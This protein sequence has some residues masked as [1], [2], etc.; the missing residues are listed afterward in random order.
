MGVG[1]SG[2]A[3]TIA[4]EVV[5]VGTLD[6]RVRFYPS[7]TSGFFMNAGLGLGT[8]SVDD[9]TEYG[10]GAMLGLGWDIRVGRNVSLTPFWNGFAMSNANGDAN[11]GQLGLGFTIH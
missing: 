11:V 4:G 5:S 3:R 8:L 10:V 7:R 1:T 6:A 9:D 2:Y